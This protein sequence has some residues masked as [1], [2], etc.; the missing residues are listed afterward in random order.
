MKVRSGFTLLELLIVVAIVAVLTALAVP[1]FLEAQTRA[2]VARIKAD[3][4]GMRT[5]LELY[6]VDHEAYPPGQFPFFPPYPEVMT[7]LLT[8]PIAYLSGIPEDIFNPRPEPDPP[9]GPFAIS[10]PYVGY[11]NDPVVME[12]WLLLSYGP[13]LDFDPGTTEIHY[14]PTNGVVSNGDIYMVGVNP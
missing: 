5:A 12:V 4:I 7:Y 13:D 8:T 11:V 2:K 10:G 9:G 3:M 1:N 6:R 14:N